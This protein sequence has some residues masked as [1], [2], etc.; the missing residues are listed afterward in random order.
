MKLEI[1]KA[2][3]RIIV[4]LAEHEDAIDDLIDYKDQEIVRSMLKVS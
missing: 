4:N 3:S 1:S 2:C